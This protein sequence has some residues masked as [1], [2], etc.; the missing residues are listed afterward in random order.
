MQMALS[1]TAAIVALTLFVF[2]TLRCVHLLA[3]SRTYFFVLLLRK[4]PLC[5][6]IFSRRENAN[7]K[8]TRKG[9]RGN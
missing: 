8:V 2:M 4:S 3:T 5:G 6:S 7:F 1:N 9:G